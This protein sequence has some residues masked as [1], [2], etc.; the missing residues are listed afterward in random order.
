MQALD[1]V[2]SWSMSAVTELLVT[3]RVPLVAGAQEA[4]VDRRQLVSWSMEFVGM[5]VA[6]AVVRRLERLRSERRA[7]V[8]W[9]GVGG[10]ETRGR[11]M[12]DD[13][14]A[15]T[16]LMNLALIASKMYSSDRVL[17]LRLFPSLELLLSSNLAE[18]LSLL[19]A[20]LVVPGTS[21]FP[22]TARRA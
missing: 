18:I 19:P 5:L 10:T 4:T 12:I 7:V 16:T 8:M 14:G 2:A 9:L 3:P 21:I 20:K 11:I 6:R 1:V 22:P 17:L 15:A 13:H